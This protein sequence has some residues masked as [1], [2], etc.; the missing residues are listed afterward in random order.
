MRLGDLLDSVEILRESGVDRDEAIHAIQYNS[1]KVQPGDVFVAIRGFTTDGHKYIE[2]AIKNKAA[3]IVVTEWQEGLSVPQVQTP[4]NRKA[5][6]QLAAQF[7]GNPSEHLTVFGITASNGKTTTANLLHAILKESGFEVGLLGTVAYEF[8]DVSIPSKLTTPESLELQQ[9]LARMVEAGVTHVVM[10]VSSQAIEQYRT[11]GIRFF[12]VSLNN[13]TREHIDQH[14]TFEA[15]WA[16]KQRLITEQP[17]GTEIVLCADDDHALSLADKTA[18]TVTLFA[19][20]AEADVRCEHLDLS[21]GVA[22]FDVRLS[23]ALRTRF[24]ALPER[25]PIALGVAGYH[26]VLNSLSAISMALL[27]GIDP[28]TIRRAAAA[29]GGVERRFEMLYQGD[30]TLLDDHFANAGNIRVSLETLKRMDYERLILVYAIRGNRGVTVNQENLEAFVPQLSDLRCA[31]FIATLSRD[32][33]DA[34][35][36]VSED[37]ERVFTSFMQTTDRPYTLHERLEDALTDASADLQKGDVVLLAGCQGMDA[38]ARLL[39]PRLA[40]RWPEKAKVLMAPLATRV[41]G[42]E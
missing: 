7:Y 17:A 29:Y 16:I 24:P 21:T 13:I 10:E 38:G 39:L 20:A 35:D 18:G 1:K 14:G 42:Q 41:A 36:T 40:D 6:A 2:E 32:V 27:A 8:G 3:C 28:E 12:G 11:Y 30:F 9:L 31:H 37:E 23:E 5:L 26:M 4:N 25:F 19:D 15:Y 34:H 33:V 22:K